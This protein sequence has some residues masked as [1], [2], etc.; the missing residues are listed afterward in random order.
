MQIYRVIVLGLLRGKAL[1]EEG[2]DLGLG[3]GQGLRVIPVAVVVVPLGPQVVP[4]GAPPTPVREPIAP[5][6]PVAPGPPELAAVGA[7]LLD[8][9]LHRH[10][11][12]R[13]VLTDGVGA[14]EVTAELGCEPLGDEPVDLGSC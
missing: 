11:A 13:E 4:P 8:A 10:A 14:V 5:V 6:T 3:H 12:R 2:V 1:G 7:P 9:V